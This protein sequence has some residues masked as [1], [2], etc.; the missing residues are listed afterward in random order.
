MEVFDRD[1]LKVRKNRI[2]DQFHQVDFLTREVAGWLFEGLD[3]VVRQFPVA[4]ELGTR[5]GHLA[6]KLAEKAGTK[7]VVLMDLSERFLTQQGGLRLVGDDGLPPFGDQTI[8]LFVSNL[9]FHFINDLPGALIQLN[10]ALKPDGL[11]LASLFG[12]DTLTELRECLMEAELEMDGGVSPRISPFTDLQDIGGLLQRA[13]FALPVVDMDT[14]TV[15]Y[16]SPFK[17]MKELQMMG[18]SN[19]LHARKKT[20]L[21]RKTLMRAAEIYVERFATMDGRIPATFQIITISAWAPHE[22]QQK[23]ARPGSATHS[24]AEALGSKEQKI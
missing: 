2:A 23:P 4:V 1:L 18:E 14:L 19:I 21:S 12:G 5:S 6:R 8:D 15:T 7:T 20:P 9:N 16:D 3:D 17:L 13:R 10:R 11:L 22:S 24:L